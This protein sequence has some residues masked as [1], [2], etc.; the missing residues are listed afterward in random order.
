M[1]VVAR[2]RVGVLSVGILGVVEVIGVLV[3]VLD[4]V[5]VSMRELHCLPLLPLPPVAECSC[6]EC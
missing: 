6:K 1:V 5:V 3:F 4:D 2:A